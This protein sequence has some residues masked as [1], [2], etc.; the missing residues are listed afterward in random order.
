MAPGTPGKTHTETGLHAARRLRAVTNKL[1][2]IFDASTGKD[3]V[4]RNPICVCLAAASAP[5]ACVTTRF[6]ES[7]GCGD[8]RRHT[9]IASALLANGCNT[10][11]ASAPSAV[12][13]D[14]AC[15]Q[16][17]KNIALPRGRRVEKWRARIGGR[18]RDARAQLR[19]GTAIGC[20]WWFAIR[21]C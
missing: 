5:A 7:T 11:E 19:Q 3:A 8:A 12:K 16:K 1:F 2:R 17:L 10:D 20:L 9:Q 21:S 4:P 18:L 13:R 14:S 6:F 15:P